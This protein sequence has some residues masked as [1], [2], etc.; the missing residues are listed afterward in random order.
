MQKSEDASTYYPAMWKNTN[1]SEHLLA[2]LRVCSRILTGGSE[3]STS[4]F[5]FSPLLPSHCAAL[6]LD[7]GWYH[8]TSVL[9]TGSLLADRTPTG[10]QG[11]FEF[12]RHDNLGTVSLLRKIK[13]LACH[14]NNH[15]RPPLVPVTCRQGPGVRDFWSELWVTSE[16]RGTWWMGWW[17]WQ[18]GCCWERYSHLETGD[19]TSNLSHG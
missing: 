6:S 8:M 14:S 7:R 10:M 5:S 19:W 18:A 9:G 4:L 13:S 1:R 17:R 11:A 3:L 16:A 12:W 2:T 15:H